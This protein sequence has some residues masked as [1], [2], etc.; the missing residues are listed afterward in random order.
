MTTID[1]ALPR[2][3]AERARALGDATAE[4]GRDF[5]LY[6]M[7]HAAR[8]HDNP[9]LDAAL[10]AANGLGLPVLVYQ[11]L[12]AKLPY[13]SDR[14]HTFILEGARDVE[15]ELAERGVAYAF[16]LAPRRDDREP[17]LELAARAA[18]VV[19]EDFP[20]PPFPRWTAKLAAASP[21]PVWAVDAAC[22]VPMRLP[23]RAFERAFEYRRAVRDELDRR[24]GEPWR[25][26]EPE[27]PAF[28]GDLGFEP[29]ALADAD[30][31]ELCARCEIDHAVGP[32]PHTRGG[33]AAG[34]RR[35]RAFVEKGGLERYARRRNDAAVAGVS[36]L[37]PYL[38]HG[39]V[40]PF[41]I[42][43]EAASEG[44]GGAEKFLD[45]LLIWRELAHNFCFHQPDPERL[46][47]L[48]AWARETL[49]RH[50]GDA[51]EAVHS[52]ERLARGRS[53]DPLW[54]AAQTSLLIHGE[55]HNNVRMTW[56]KALL[57]WTRSPAD[58]LRRLVD[59]NHRYALDGSD[60]SSYGGLLWCL[61]LFDRPFKPERPV[62]GTVRPRSTAGHARRLDLE[63]YRARF[64]GPARANGP[65]VAVVGAGVAGL[66]AARTL[67]DH[68]LE[69]RVFDKGRGPGG[70]ISTR[71][72]DAFRFDHGAQYFTARDPRFRRYVDAWCEEGVARPWGG[73]IAV[74]EGG[75]AESKQDGPERFVG[76]PGM[77]AVARHL[78]ADL[79]VASATRV[80][81]V[82]GRGSGWRLVDGDG[83]SL[84][85]FGAL[86]VA[87]PPAQAAEL[88]TAAPEL[89]RRTRAVAM[90][91]CWAVM[92]A[93][94]ERLDLPFDGAFVHGSPLS[95]VARNG[96]KPGRPDPE[97][98]VLHGS[99]G[100]SA[101]H[102]EGDPDE[103]Q[104]RLLEAFFAA[105]ALEPRA[106]RF[107]RAHRWRYAIAEEPLDAGC[108]WDAD[109][110]IGACGDWCAGSRVE[111]AFLSGMAAA[112]RVL[113]L[114]DP[115]A[116]GLR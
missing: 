75:R 79:E 21:A 32:V 71:R 23:G 72:H 105:T 115:G 113:G 51:R 37:S 111:G 96:S 99:P 82:K 38:H 114:P 59:L 85:E 66:F 26:V 33:S 112:G 91:P 24:V 81:A 4:G 46:A 87:V 9:A 108:L 15:R 54:D 92:A 88:L 100:W 61:G 48:P 107:V 77:S 5:V 55:L 2:H 43:R 74:L 93:F 16:H 110:R 53:G 35:W 80:G 73:R 95:W 30:L 76:V 65:S 109:L 45:E 84:G 19:V 44:S 18:L 10:A 31:A 34:Y 106:P 98:W 42:A 103:A 49:E 41:R 27:A 13:A 8:G 28:A 64:T 89:E 29:V 22:V 1:Q 69:V 63:R 97:S 39:H 62:L 50:A 7:H 40:S 67:R 6:W 68:G 104:D 36:R 3:L 12:S 11:G 47:A 83:A 56:G 60:P 17:L 20:A 52:R 86:L 58:A 70:R 90:R 101:R 78:G 57:R 94:D 102:L 25:D 116:P 14:H